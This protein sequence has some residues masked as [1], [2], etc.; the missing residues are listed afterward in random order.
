MMKRLQIFWLRV[1]PALMTVTK[2]SPIKLN[3][4]R[5]QNLKFNPNPNPNPNP[6][7]SPVPP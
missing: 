1:S 4:I 6:L 5:N 2:L 7:P 3:L